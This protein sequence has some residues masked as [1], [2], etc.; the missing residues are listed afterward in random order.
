MH[1]AMSLGD[2]YARESRVIAF[3]MGYNKNMEKV[4]SV[5]M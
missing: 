3:V 1:H 2:N 5:F 4:L